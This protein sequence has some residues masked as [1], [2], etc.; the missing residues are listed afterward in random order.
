LRT[1]F[2][3]LVLAAATL[4]TAAQAQIRALPEHARPGTMR[5]EQD[6]IVQIDGRFAQL[7]PGAQI[8]DIENRV[9]LPVMV[10]P[11]SW[12]KYTVDREGLVDRVWILSPLEAARERGRTRILIVP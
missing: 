9:V 11:G 10:P 3:I 7:A 4:A 5:H 12:V 8:R 1:T 2:G 6:M